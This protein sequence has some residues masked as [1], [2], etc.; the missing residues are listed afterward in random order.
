VSVLWLLDKW[1][2]WR[3][4]KSGKTRAGDRLIQQTDSLWGRSGP[5][6]N[7]LPSLGESE[8]MEIRVAM[9]PLLFQFISVLGRFWDQGIGKDRVGREESLRAFLCFK[10]NLGI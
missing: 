6:I 8:S 9:K 10:R 5:V 7:K 3:F 2:D 4:G 1:R